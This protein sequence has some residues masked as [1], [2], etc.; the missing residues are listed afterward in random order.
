MEARPDFPLAGDSDLAI[1]AALTL[2]YGVPNS[3]EL[4][5]DYR[6]RLR[7]ISRLS[8]RSMPSRSSQPLI[9]TS[10]VCLHPADPV[11]CSV[12]KFEND[13]TIKKELDLREGIMSVAFLPLVWQ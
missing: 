13:I 7:H 12:I 11:A 3:M 1:E 8:R 4:R 6:V 5:K 10:S 2:E 9:P